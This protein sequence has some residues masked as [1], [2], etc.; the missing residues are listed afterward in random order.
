MANDRVQCRAELNDEGA[1]VMG[2]QANQVGRA[3]ERVRVD[4]KVIVAVRAARPKGGDA[5][6]ARV[7]SVPVV[8]QVVPVGGE[9]QLVP[10]KLGG[11]RGDVQVESADVKVDSS[12]CIDISAAVAVAT[13]TED[14]R[15]RALSERGRRAR[16]KAAAVRKAGAQA[17]DH[18]EVVCAGPHEVVAANDRRRVELPGGYAPVP[19]GRQG[20]EALHRLGG[21]VG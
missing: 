14:P 10:A 15:S 18:P 21:L 19:H 2:G 7:V 17:R 20:A 3:R 9:F 6:R 11:E 4:V 8:P 13:V 16:R 1:A 5:V 12:R